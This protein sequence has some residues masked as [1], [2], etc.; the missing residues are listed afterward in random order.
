M[1]TEDSPADTAAEAEEDL[2]LTPEQDVAL[3]LDQN[4]AITAGAGTG[5]TTTLTERYR[6]IL[7]TEPE[8]HP[9]EILTL[10]FTNDATNE[11]RDRIRDVIDDEL[12]AASATEYDRWRRAKD[13]LEDAYIH[14][15]H[16]F[17]SRVLREFAVE[18]AVHPDFET[19][20]EG[21]SGTVI[22]EAIT[23]VLDRYG[24]DDGLP[25]GA[26]RL[27]VTDT[28]RSEEW[29]WDV[30]AELSTLTRLYSR[31]GLE[32]ALA[33]L[34]AERP[35]STE[36]ADRWA[37]Q[38]P[39]DY[40]A[41]CSDFLEVS[42]PPSEA[43]ELIETS[44]AQDAIAELQ[45][46][47]ARDVDV[48][49]DDNGVEVLAD[50][51]TF[52]EETGAHR[53]DGDRIH[54]QRFLLKVADAVTTGSGSLQSQTWRYAGS[55]GTWSDHGHSDERARLKDAL[56]TLAAVIEP[57]KR[58]LDYDP[59]VERN[60]AR[61][62]IALARVFQTVQDEY[63]R[64]K[65][66]R[67]ALD[68]SDLIT[69]TIDFLE[70]H[71][72]A[73]QSLRD[74]FEYI[75]VDEVQD[76]DPRQWK[77]VKLL[78]GD[79][80]DAFDGQN[81]FLVGDEKQSIY[82]FRDADVTQFRDARTTLVADNPSAVTGD[83]ELTGNFRTIDPTLTVINEMFAEILQPS[84][85]SDLGETAEADDPDDEA[86]Q[87]AHE[88]YE[89]EP[90]WLDTCRQEGTAIEGTV[91]YLIVPD[92]EDADTALGLD[93]TWFT[94]DEFISR[95][96]REAKAIAARL[97]Q[98]FEQEVEV[99]DPDQDDCV[100]IQPRHVALLFRSSRRLAAFER[101]FEE[102]EIPYTNL[103]GSGFYETPEVRPLINLLKI[104]EDPKADIPLYGVLRSPLFGFADKK[105]A[106]AREPD[107]PLWECLAAADP[108]LQ[109]AREQISAWRET[110]G[111]T[112]ETAVAQWSTLLSQII[113]ETGY[114]IAIGA[115]DRPQ[116]AVANIEKFREQLR[117]WEEGSARSVTNLIDR[118]EQAREGD[119]D[120]SEATVP[121]DVEGVELR[122]IH[123]AKGLEFPIVVVPEVTRQF[124]MRSS[125][126]K[127]H[128][129]RIDDDPVL[130]LKAPSADNVYDSTNT[131]TYLHV[132][133]QHRSRERAEQRRL[134]YVA[135]T[136]T[137]DH[138]LLSGTHGV[139]G[140][141]AS[142]LD[143]P[144]VTDDWA[145]AWDWGDWVQP[146]LLDEPDLVSRL[147]AAPRIETSIGEAT[148]TI[149]RPTPPA[150]WSPSGEKEAIPSDLEIPAPDRSSPRL[151]LSATDFRDRL[152][153]AATGDWPAVLRESA[154][155]N[156]VGPT[157]I[158]DEMAIDALDA[159]AV[160][161]VVH[162]LCE[163]DLPRSEWPAIIRRC[164]ETPGEVSERAFDALAAHTEAGL[165]GLRDV[166]GDQTVLSRH[167]ELSVTV[168]LPAA[169]VVG[170]IDH[171]SVTPN[172]YLVVDY[173]TSD[174]DGNSL[175]ELTEHYLPQLVAYAGALLHNDETAE[176][177]EIA[178]VFTDTGQVKQRTLSRYK[179][180]ELLDWANTLLTKPA[181]KS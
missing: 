97:T 74:Q 99:Y 26:G 87:A 127:G 179:V 48:P 22:D 174:L 79:D 157:T 165:A 154:D 33:S 121:G 152:A 133:S 132:R 38:A 4:I 149:R 158:D 53:L 116:Q 21:D 28:D 69:Q 142:G 153:D 66:R 124:N 25:S 107:T 75:M 109:A 128:L 168:D 71:D 143:E 77:L 155:N 41:Y 58:N 46:I 16:G 76:T 35:D 96:E 171:L 148:Y 68:Y 17:C 62:A 18:A 84:A 55:K 130:G 12:T 7:T 63:E 145:G 123:S 31:S 120:P 92:D 118:I 64:M 103:A 52:L 122:T 125:I 117:N 27:D 90:Q 36:W 173:K 5:K 45:H 104:F 9:D 93:G 136:R 3:A 82:R 72:R 176:R 43:D 137:R 175:P 70:T 160:G 139:D 49:A 86:E 50:L 19:L 169:R 78:S 119:E 166:E 114:L 15:I 100:P 110:I 61:Q 57:E 44:A 134:L 95:A 34:F 129:E 141:S 59:V 147:A 56:D 73:R 135:A 54:R 112:D 101:E 23:T 159:A 91:E 180:E 30:R 40:L 108:E 85:R 6:E 150:A 65:T 80:P 60:G 8:T 102:A 170:D 47:V 89:A 39:A 24:I 181:M 11:M 156:A 131:A 98:L 144:D 20:D 162:K 167:S 1:M 88:S 126:S 164:V 140:E 10:T 138:L 42:I 29:D 111:L 37:D 113:D 83:L 172:G 51:T 161:T 177:V 94:E 178:L 32:S 81:V 67:T 106:L 146:T 105:I 163:L 115:D 14:T 13:D 2:S 151:R